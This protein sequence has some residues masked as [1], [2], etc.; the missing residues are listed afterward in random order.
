MLHPLDEIAPA[1]CKP[2]GTEHSN[3]PHLISYRPPPP[4]VCVAFT[5]WHSCVLF[6][7]F[8]K[9]LVCSMRPTPPWRSCLPV[10]SPLWLFSMTPCREY[11]PYGPYAKSQATWV[12]KEAMWKIHMGRFACCQVNI[13]SLAAIRSVQLF[14]HIQLIQLECHWAWSHRGL[15]PL[16]SGK[17]PVLSPLWAVE[18][19]ASA[20]DLDQGV[21]HH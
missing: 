1:V 6:P 19:M 21:Q 4:C 17:S 2:T 8:S 14:C 7:S 20:L 11:T 5:A 15:W 9:A 13:V 12:F 3:T 10:A 18:H 16:T